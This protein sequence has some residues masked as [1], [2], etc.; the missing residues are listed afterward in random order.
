MKRKIFRD[1]IIGCFLISTLSTAVFIVSCSDDDI[2]STL[3]DRNNNYSLHSG[4]GS[5]FL[6]GVTNLFSGIGTGAANQIGVVGIG[7]AFGALGLSSQSPDYTNQLNIIADDLQDITDAINQTNTELTNIE[8]TLS[9]FKCDYES[10][11]IYGDISAIKNWYGQYTNIIYTASTTHDTIPNADMISLTNG[12][13][14]GVPGGTES[15]TDAMNNIWVGMNTAITTCIDTLQSPAAGT[16]KGDSVYYNSALSTLY[17][18]YY[19]Q[20]VGLG[21][22]SEAYHYSAWV[23]A[24]SMGATTGYSSDSV[25]AICTGID[26]NI[27]NVA[28]NCNYVLQYS[29]NVYNSLLPQFQT[30]GAPYTG[31]DFIYQKTPEGQDLVWVRSLEDFTAQSGANCNLSTPLSMQYHDYNVCG[32]TVGLKGSTL[33]VTS[34]RGTQGF[35]FPAYQQFLSLVEG[36]NLGN[37]GFEN[38]EYKILIG[39]TL[40]VIGSTDIPSNA[41][42]MFDTI[43]VVPFVMNNH[44][45]STTFDFS[46]SSYGI[47]SS[48]GY[49]LYGSCAY[50]ININGTVDCSHSN[51]TD[52]AFQVV[53]ETILP[54]FIWG[55]NSQNYIATGS[56]NVC[57]SPGPEVNCILGSFIWQSTPPGWSYGAVNSRPLPAFQIPVKSSFSGTSGCVSY[58]NPNGGVT[59]Y[60]NYNTTGVITICNATFQEFIGVNFPAPATCSSNIVVCNS[61]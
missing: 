54:D 45:Y 18:Y 56:D 7:W 22:L 51:G 25:M 2:L 26:T 57:Y 58:T 31:E 4:A 37:T 14:N 52:D 21:L 41:Q 17:Y 32:P 60:S 16:F 39:D 61:Y 19:W 53:F 55:G 3:A 36:N 33:S 40:V 28:L 49:T 6:A 59:Y 15:V 9:A 12:I 34:Y 5:L 44:L 27:F 48:I 11:L 46:G 30:I 10:S 50:S 42:D 38:M 23:S 1:I 13:L 8:N 29:N 35:H 43:S 24:D 20:S 47:L